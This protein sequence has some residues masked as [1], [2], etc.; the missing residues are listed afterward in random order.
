MPLALDSRRAVFVHGDPGYDTSAALR[1][2]RDRQQRL[3]EALRER[4]GLTV[5]A[6]GVTGARRKKARRN[7]RVRTA[8]TLRLARPPGAPGGY[9]V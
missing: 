9:R 4:Q 6:V 5:E 3:W 7:G 8:R 1:S 2:W